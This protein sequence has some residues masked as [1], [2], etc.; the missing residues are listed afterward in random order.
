VTVAVPS[1]PMLMGTMLMIPLAPVV[2]LLDVL[3]SSFTG[4]WFATLAGAG[5]GAGA[6][7]GVGEG[8]GWSATAAAGLAVC[9]AGAGGVGSGGNEEEEEEEDGNVSVTTFTPSPAPEPAFGSESELDE[10]A[11]LVGVACGTTTTLMLVWRTVEVASGEDATGTGCG[12]GWMMVGEYEG[13]DGGGG[14]ELGESDILEVTCATA[15]WPAEEFGSDESLLESVADASGSTMTLGRPLGGALRRPKP[16][17]K[18]EESEVVDVEAGRVSA[19]SILADVVVWGEKRGT[20]AW[21]PDCC[22]IEAGPKAELEV[23]ESCTVASG[24]V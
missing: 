2:V 23:G 14:E 19:A 5:A 16:E 11:A 4:P 9:G 17:K 3:G 13:V 22:E 7:E 8:A 18:S 24:A 12:E 21:A 15:I 20:V 6:G 10:S 1:A